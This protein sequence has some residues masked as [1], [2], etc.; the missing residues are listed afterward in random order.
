M[1]PRLRRVRPSHRQARVVAGVKHSRWRHRVATSCLCSRMP[2][3]KA[4]AD[5]SD[6]QENPESDRHKLSQDS[7]ELARFRE[8]WRAEVNY[9]KQLV[10]GGGSDSTSKVEEEDKRPLQDVL[11]PSLGGTTPLGYTPMRRPEGPPL[12]VPRT[13]RT[14]VLATTKTNFTST[15]VRSVLFRLC[16]TFD[17][18]RSEGVCDRTLW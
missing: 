10:Q 2:Q 17:S 9:R 12:S 5:E 14:T 18:H 7:D 8:A 11:A 16:Q 6:L 4:L 3:L 1:Y 15:Q 13:E